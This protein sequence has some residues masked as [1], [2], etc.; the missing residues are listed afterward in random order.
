MGLKLFKPKSFFCL[1]FL[2]VFVYVAVMIIYMILTS[3]CIVQM[4]LVY[5][6]SIVYPL[7]KCSEL[8]NVIF[9]PFF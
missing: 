2:T 8:V 7:V 1:Y 9:I 3:V 4:Y 5:D 6:L